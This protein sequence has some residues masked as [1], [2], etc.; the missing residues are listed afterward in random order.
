MNIARQII[1][2]ELARMEAANLEVSYREMEE[3]CQ[4]KEWG[5]WGRLNNDH[6]GYPRLP[7][8]SPKGWGEPDYS[9][10]VAD[11][12]DSVGERIDAAISRLPKVHNQVIK[13]IYLYRVPWLKLPL[14]LRMSRARIES[15][16]NQSIGIVWDRLRK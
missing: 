6:L 15:Y 12:Q 11:I 7:A 14:L 4:L 5:K 2:E 10:I 3:E 13:A 1:T 9:E 16:Q 8:F